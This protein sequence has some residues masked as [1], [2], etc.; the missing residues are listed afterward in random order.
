MTATARRRRDHL[1]R[2]CSR[3]SAEYP[4]GG[5]RAAWV[6]ILGYL[7]TPIQE[8]LAGC[9]LEGFSV[10]YAVEDNALGTAGGIK[11]AQRYLKNRGEPVVLGGWFIGSEEPLQKIIDRKKHYRRLCR[12]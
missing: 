1:W 3:P 11:N 12:A 5:R 2:I 7:P 6:E 8:Y 10:D 4:S 9:D